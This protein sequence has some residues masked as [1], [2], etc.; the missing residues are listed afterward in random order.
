MRYLAFP[1]VLQNAPL[2][3]S[4]IALPMGIYRRGVIM[5]HG[6]EG[7]KSHCFWVG[8][9]VNHHVKYTRM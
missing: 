5:A 6:S 1:Q 4:L 3:L 8:F 9:P 2:S 7:V